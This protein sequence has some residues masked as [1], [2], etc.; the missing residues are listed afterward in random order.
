MTWSFLSIG[1]G[2]AIL[3]W[4]SLFPLRHYLDRWQAIDIPNERSSHTRPTT[5]GGGLV[6][7]A[8]TLV[9][10]LLGI[11]NGPAN[12]WA[13]PLVFVGSAALVALV[14]W[15]D[16]L[17]SL[18]SR[19]RFA[20]HSGAAL[21]VMAA[22]GWWQVVNLPLI[23]EVQ[24]GWLGA[25]A[26]FV[27]IVGLTN[28]YNFMDGIDGIA[29]TQ[30]VIA[31]L[32]WAIFSI[33]YGAWLG[34]LLAILIAATS[35]G[36]LG[37]NW[38]PA[39]IFMGDVGSAF[40]GYSLAVLPLIIRAETQA[41]VASLPLLALLIVWPFVWD[42]TFTIIRRWRRGENIWAAHRSHLYQ[43]LVIAG[44]RHAPVT[45]LYAG[46]ALLGVALAYLVVRAPGIAAWLIMLALPL[47]AIGLY[48]L[49]LNQE[50]RDT[51]INVVSSYE[52]TS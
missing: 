12:H 46:L 43:R 37:H 15:I 8:V 17:R 39:R 49:V 48:L 18:S 31:G 3:A 32:A 42:T 28:A 51:Q 1:V 13:A 26:T 27:W 29:G 22:F 30:A 16:D 5:R 35:L 44:W 47:S 33:T 2:A 20:A 7:A 36:F 25:V 38:A 14:S 45:L 23:G 19:V 11:A 4:A 21:L 9:G 52:T 10:A 24:Q 34:A 6:I 41:H 40:L 50:R